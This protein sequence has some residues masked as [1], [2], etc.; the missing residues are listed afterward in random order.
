LPSYC[1]NPAVDFTLGKPLGKLTSSLLLGDVSM[2]RLLEYSSLRGWN[3]YD[4]AL[5]VIFAI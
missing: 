5:K 1:G 2:N 3:T 4:I